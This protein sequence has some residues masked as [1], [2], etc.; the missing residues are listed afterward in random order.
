MSQ[1]DQILDHLQQGFT[2]TRM[3]ALEWFGCIEAPTRI[4]EL[5]EQGFNIKKN[6]VA[7]NGKLVAEYYMEFKPQ[8]EM[9]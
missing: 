9:F 4:F 1:R 6:M 8:R 2:L 3:Q 7:V 5:K